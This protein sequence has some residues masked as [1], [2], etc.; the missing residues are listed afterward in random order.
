[1]DTELE[2]RP[3]LLVIQG[4]GGSLIEHTP[5]SPIGFVILDPSPHS[6]LILAAEANTKKIKCK[7][8]AAP[9]LMEV[10]PAPGLLFIPG[11]PV[12]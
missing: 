2:S 10:H 1:M 5:R 12:T 3:S 11:V 7:V 4:D 8:T 6:T 9:K